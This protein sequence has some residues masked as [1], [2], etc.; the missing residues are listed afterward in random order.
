[1]ADSKKRK[2]G[3]KVPYKEIALFIISLAA[4][5]VL[6]YIILKDS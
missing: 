1:M 6:A 5:T 2:K 3:K 4:I